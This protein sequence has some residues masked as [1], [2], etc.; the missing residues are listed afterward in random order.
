VR[1]VSETD[2]DRERQRDRETESCEELPLEKLET[3]LSAGIGVAKS[4]AANSPSFTPAAAEWELV[5]FSTASER[6]RP[7]LKE[8]EVGSPTA[9]AKK[10]TERTT[11]ARIVGSTSRVLKRARPD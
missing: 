2:R 6:E 9:E 11:A 10:A 8:A 4:A 1:Q 7:P 5:T 3:L